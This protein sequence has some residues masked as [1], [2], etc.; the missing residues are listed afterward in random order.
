MSLRV[1]LIGAFVGMLAALAGLGAW[2][3]W[4]LDDMGEVSSRII[5]DNYDS[6]VAA[7]QMKESLERQDSAM[8]FA[9][10]GERE[11][12][13]RQLIEH[14]ARFAAALAVAAGNL[15]EPGERELVEAIRLQLAQSRLHRVE[16]VSRCAVDHV[17]RAL[18]QG[19]KPGFHRE[20][21]VYRQ[22]VSRVERRDRSRA[23]FL[24]ILA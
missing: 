7:Q 15:T 18:D 20:R 5:A 19:P 3:A 12:A 2:S 6:V 13:A 1:R 23:P 11:R 22:K 9:L 17:S 10:L 4:R 14:R 8:L 24:P 21:A 16:A